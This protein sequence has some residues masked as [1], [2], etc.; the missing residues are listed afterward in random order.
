MGARQAELGRDLVDVGARD[1]AP[2]PVRPAQPLEHLGRR[3]AVTALE[4]AHRPAGHQS[5][6]YRVSDRRAEK[7]AGMAGFRVVI[8]GAG[9]AGLETMLAL[10]DLAAEFVEIQILD[11][12]D[13]FVYR[14]LLVAEPFGLETH[15]TTLDLAPIVEAAGGRH[16]RD[17]LES[18]QPAGGT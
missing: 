8:A 11:P 10:D 5:L 9:V 13:A 2:V 6:F 7:M 4:L 1:P 17:A 18:V 14:P 16:I 12:A 3:A 15:M